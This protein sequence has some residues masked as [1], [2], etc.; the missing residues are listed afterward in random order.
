MAQVNQPFK[1]FSSADIVNNIARGSKKAYVV[2]SFGGKY[3]FI[4][5]YSNKNFQGLFFLKSDLDDIT[6]SAFAKSKNIS[7]AFKNMYNG[8]IERIKQ[9]GHSFK[10]LNLFE[11]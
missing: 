5:N 4:P 10:F 11:N 3:E 2:D 7:E 1:P 6:H 8:F 9:D